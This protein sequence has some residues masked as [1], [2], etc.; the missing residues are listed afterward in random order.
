MTD[1]ALTAPSAA[2]IEAL[3]RDVL[4]SLPPE[5][6][7]HAQTVLLEVAEFADE[8]MLDELQIDDPFELTGLYDGVPMTEKLDSAP[9]S[10]PDRVLLFR[11]PIL[12]E[13]AARGDVTL[14]DL[15]RN[16]VVHEFAHHFGWSDAQ[17]AEIDRW[18]E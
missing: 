9:Q 16:V 2:Q 11:R 15:V 10:F 1:T 13:W 5:F 7:Q 14:H 18:W 6:A 8:D 17:I 3:A 4:A 12:D